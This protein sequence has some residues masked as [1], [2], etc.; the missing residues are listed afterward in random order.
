MSAARIIGAVF[1]V[2]LLVGGFLGTAISVIAILDPVGTQ[3]SDD[4][5]PFGP[6]RSFFSSVWILVF[7]LGVG[8]IGFILAWRSVRKRPASA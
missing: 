6:P 2:V 5:N 1:G 3:L 4:S 8:A 7:Y